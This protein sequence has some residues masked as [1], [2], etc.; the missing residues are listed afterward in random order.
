M[1][2]DDATWGEILRLWT[3][4]S[5][6]PSDIGRRFGVTHQKVVQVAIARSWPE[7]LGPISKPRK[8]RETSAATVLVRSS[9]KPVRRKGGTDVEAG[10]GEGELLQRLY[11]AIERI[12]T[13]IEDRMAQEQ[14]ETLADTERL[15]RTL[16]TLI[17]NIGKIQDV[18]DQFKRRRSTAKSKNKATGDAERRRNELAARV[19]RI[20]GDGSKETG[21]GANSS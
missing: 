9:R 20:L 8:H 11:E 19:C 13:A 14:E 1:S 15:V 2:V 10:V 4:T 17:Q 3:E 5:E 18:D 6:A 21:R 12:V 16:G 7:R